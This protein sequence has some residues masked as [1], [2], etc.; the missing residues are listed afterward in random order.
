VAFAAVV[1]TVVCAAAAAGG[2]VIAAAPGGAGASPSDLALAVEWLSG[3][4]SSAAQAAA[5]TTYLD[6]RLEIVP[7]WRDRDDGHWLYVEQAAAGHLDRPY[8]QRIY[9]VVGYSSGAVVS[10]VFTIPDPLRFAGA[11]R[12]EAPL[13][14]LSPDSLTLREGCGVILRRTQKTLFGGGTVGE[15]CESS[16]RG[17]SYATSEVALTPEKLVSWDRG[18]D[19][20]GRQVWGA[21]GGPYVFD[22]ITRRDAGDAGAPAG[23]GPRDP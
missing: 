18:F 6:I 7:I 12:D 10:D 11:W 23:A 9:H 2:T 8:R 21:V 3:S 4:F 16:L 1:A 15:G 22:R 5:D 13:A 17:A 19:A 20:D 14:T